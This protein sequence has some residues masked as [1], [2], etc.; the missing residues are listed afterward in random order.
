MNNKKKYDI[1]YYIDSLEWWE[2]KQNKYLVHFV[3]MNETPHTKII[4]GE[5]ILSAY[6]DKLRTCKDDIND[7]EKF[8]FTYKILNNRPY[9]FRYDYTFKKYEDI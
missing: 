3:C 8:T 9:V 2:D 7:I 1:F 5:I 4:D 6:I